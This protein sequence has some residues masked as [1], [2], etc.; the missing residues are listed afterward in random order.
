MLYITPLDRFNVDRR[1]VLPMEHLSSGPR[2]R[3][4]GPPA[5]FSKCHWFCLVTGHNISFRRQTSLAKL[6]LL[7]W[8][9]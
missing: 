2:Q 1:R 4:H 3:D 5:S 8:W 6:Q 7:F 9:E